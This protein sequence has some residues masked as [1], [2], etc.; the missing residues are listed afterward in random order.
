MRLG[1]N[2]DHIATLRQARLGIE[3]E[4]LYAAFIAQEALADNI[5]MHLREDRRHIQESDVI[6]VVSSLKIPLNLEMSIADDIVQFALEVKPHQS[7]L[8][9][10]KRKELTTEGGLDVVTNFEKLK[11]VIDKLHSKDI[12]VSL[13]IDPDKKQIEAAKKLNV[14]SIEMHTGEYANAPISQKAKFANIIADVAALAKSLGLN[15]HAGHGLNYQNVSPIAKIKEI[16]E[17]NI[18]HSIISRAVFCGLKEA[19]LQMK[20]IIEKARWSV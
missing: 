13:F 8:V 16:E 10:E 1:V 20:Q 17:L 3:P 7:T 4:P 15:V 2:I 14:D 5:T 9:P 11:E 19:I 12:F 18:G 6:A